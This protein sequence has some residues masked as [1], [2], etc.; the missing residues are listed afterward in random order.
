VC[1]A[2]LVADAVYTWVAIALDS[3][4]VGEK[5]GAVGGAGRLDR[6]DGGRGFARVG[7]ASLALAAPVLGMANTDPLTW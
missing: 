2:L 6:L 5:S 7:R 1:A 4:A 3:G